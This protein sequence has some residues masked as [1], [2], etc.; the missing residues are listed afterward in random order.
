MPL[1]AR[2]VLSSLAR[3]AVPVLGLAVAAMVGV[4]IRHPV[5]LWTTGAL[6]A[7]YALSGST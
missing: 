2:G 6:A 5:L 7:G 3:P 4:A 1:S